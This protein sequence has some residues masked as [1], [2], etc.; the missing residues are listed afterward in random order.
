MPTARETTNVNVII[1]V[2]VE[3]VVWT[4]HDLTKI[5]ETFV[6]APENKCHCTGNR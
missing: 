4:G 3:D 2:I 5:T 6:A 1:E